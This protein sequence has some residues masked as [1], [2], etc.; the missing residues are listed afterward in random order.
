VRVALV[1]MEVRAGD[2]DA[3]VREFHR[4][5]EEALKYNP[6]IIVFPEYCLTGFEMWDF[7]GADLYHQI[8][9]IAVK[10]ALESKVHL[11]LG[12]L[13]R[14][15][16]CVYN[17]AIL[18]SPQGRVILRHRKFQEPMK[19]CT[20]SR[21]PVI[22]TRWGRVSVIICGDL[23]NREIL[24]E[25]LSGKP[26]YLFVP[27]E[28]TPDHGPLNDEDIRAMSLRIKLMGT[29]ALIV[30]SFPPGGAWV[31]DKGGNLMASSN[32]SNLLVVDV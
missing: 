19:F 20:G 15:G 30:N 17:S 26:D 32:G 25:I 8:L 11:I 21:V 16:V 22:D 27:M 14:A 10:T 28:Y 2:F 13:E 31:F 23:Y 18:V 3:N 9:N 5:M 29:T 24:Q 1:P 12:L 7:S 4:R 6:D